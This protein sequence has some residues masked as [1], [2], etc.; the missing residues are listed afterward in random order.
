MDETEGPLYQ[1]WRSFIVQVLDDPDI[2]VTFAE[3]LSGR[4]APRP[5]GQYL[6]IN[7]ISGPSSFSGYPD[8]FRTPGS[9]PATFSL[10]QMEQYTV[11]IQAF[12]SGSRAL[13]EKIRRFLDSPIDREVLQAADIAIVDKGSVQNISV[14]LDVGFERRHQLDVIFNSSKVVETSLSSI[15]QATIEGTLKEGKEGSH[16]A[17]PFTVTDS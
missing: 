11:S 3:E 7:I 8:M 13:L 2:T 16:S 1:G 5:Q 17:G 15:D 6:T 4:D 9:D 10:R 12:R 14:P